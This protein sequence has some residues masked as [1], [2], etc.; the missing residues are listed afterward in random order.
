MATLPKYIAETDTPFGCPTSERLT[1]PIR[2]TTEAFV[3]ASALCTELCSLHQNYKNNSTLLNQNVLCN[4]NTGYMDS[5]ATG[6]RK[7]IC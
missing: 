7:I 3:E 6:K 5:V 4:S 2:L 1:A